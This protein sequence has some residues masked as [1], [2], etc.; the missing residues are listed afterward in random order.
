MSTGRLPS[1]DGG[2]QPTIVDAK[3]DLIVATAAD[4]VSRLA[5]GSNDQVLTA[6]STT[7]TGVKWAAAASG[8]ANWTL[9]NSG[10]TL[11][12]GSST[13]TVSGISGKDK[14]FVLIDSASCADAYFT[15]RLRLNTDTGSNYNF[16]GTTITANS[17]YAASNFSG[18]PLQNNTSYSLA[19][20]SS[21]TS[22]T[23]SGYALI[24]GANSSG[25]K[26]ITSNAGG[27]PSGGNTQGL[28]N[29][30]GFYNSSS[31]ISSVSLVVTGSFDAG[32]MYVYTSA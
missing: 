30:G 1:V 29:Y 19:N 11:L 20:I 4:T 9:L 10:G 25:V 12:S 23:V 15:I 18:E 32:T 27:T 5:V 17:T 7:A 6:D 16:A 13:V 31:T 26:V 24:T 3:G 21:N 2:I 14:I 22:S 28:Y 8:G